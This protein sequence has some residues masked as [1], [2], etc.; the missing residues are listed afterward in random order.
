MYEREERT[1]VRTQLPWLLLYHPACCL[2]PLSF[3]FFTYT[4]F[5]LGRMS[6]VMHLW[7]LPI[8]ITYTP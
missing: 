2:P 3:S 5:F 8:K 7:H 4:A 6:E 1:G